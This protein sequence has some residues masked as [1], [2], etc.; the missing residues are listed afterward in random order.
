M[1]NSRFGFTTLQVCC[2]KGIASA[3]LTVCE[4]I[5]Q[6]TQLKSIYLHAWQFDAGA[7]AFYSGAGY[8]VAGKDS[9]LAAVWHGLTPRVLFY[10]DLPAS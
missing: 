5:T 10:K 3:L 7:Q 9:G 6:E 2:R 4:Q 1:P 8:K